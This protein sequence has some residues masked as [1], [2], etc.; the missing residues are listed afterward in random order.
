MIQII[1]LVCG[2]ISFL[3]GIYM[4]F[5]RYSEA[6]SAAASVNW[7]TAQGQMLSITMRKFGFPRPAFVPSAEYTFSA[8]SREQK[9][10]RIGYRVIASRDEKE[11]E[12]VIAK[13]PAGS[14][15]KVTYNPDDPR[16]SSIESGPAG[17]RVFTSDVIW[18]LCVGFFCTGANL[19]LP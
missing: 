12:Q 18:L 19:L 2:I 14:K 10:K 6:R 13:Y 16:D 4:A 8:N 17:T 15:V 3:G 5:V 11:I 7:P 1:G 9:G